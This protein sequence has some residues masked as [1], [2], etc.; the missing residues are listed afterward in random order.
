MEESKDEK[1]DKVVYNGENLIQVLAMKKMSRK[2]F[3]SLM[4]WRFPNQVDTFMRGNPTADTLAK[5]C[6]VLDVCVSAFFD[7]EVKVEDGTKIEKSIIWNSLNRTDGI[8]RIID[9]IQEQMKERRVENSQKNDLTNEYIASL[10][11]QIAYL[12]ERIEELRTQKSE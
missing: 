6:S 2:D 11:E 1:N 10:K 12:K 3:M 9:L 8:H 5:V 7:Q 4:G